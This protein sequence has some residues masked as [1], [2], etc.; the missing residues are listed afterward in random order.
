MGSFSRRLLAA[1]LVLGA[2]ATGC[3]GDGDDDDGA[4]P[5]TKDGSTSTTAEPDFAFAVVGSEV[6]AMAPQTPAFPADVSEAVTA[7]LDSWLG[8]AIVEPLRTGKPAAGLEPLFTEPA[9]GKIAVPGAER[10]AMV[11]EGSPLSGKVTQERANVRL[12]AVTGPGGSVEFVTAQ[13]DMAH[14]VPSN[15]GFVDLVRSGELVLVP[16]EGAWRIDAFDVVAKR[17]TRAP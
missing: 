11:E 6:H 4:T 5:G 8:A 1:L 13:I 9:L 2:L 14:A 16:H 10:A 15:D 3:S 7:S 12:T 17:D